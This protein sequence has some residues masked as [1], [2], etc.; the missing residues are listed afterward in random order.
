MDMQYLDKFQYN[1]ITILPFPDDPNDRRTK[2][3]FIYYV[4]GLADNEKRFYNT[5]LRKMRRFLNYLTLRHKH[6]FIEYHYWYDG[7]PL[8]DEEL[9]S[10]KNLPLCYHTRTHYQG[11]F[12]RDLL[13]NVKEAL[14]NVD[15]CKLS[16]QLQNKIDNALFIYR[17]AFFQQTE[18]MRLTQLFIALEALS[19]K[20]EISFDV[21]LKQE[22]QKAINNIL[23]NKQLTKTVIQKIRSYIGRLA[24]DGPRTMMRNTLQ[25]YSIP[26]MDGNR[27]LD[28]GKLYNVRCKIVHEGK[29]IKDCHKSCMKMEEIISILVS[30]LINEYSN[31]KVSGSGLDGN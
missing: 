3:V 29:T 7:S 1:N 5:A 19:E 30:R 9:F 13:F 23:N 18:E 21:E 26:I 10:H 4:K 15:Q 17:N 22:I 14:K 6:G 12:C 8:C 25:K 27:K 16:I 24:D 20:S 11:H 28:I 31:K 2:G